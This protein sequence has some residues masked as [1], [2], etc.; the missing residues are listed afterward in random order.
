VSQIDLS[1]K[2][3]RRN[4]LN[5]AKDNKSGHLACAMS[6]VEIVSSLYGETI[7]FNVNDPEDPNRDI[8]ALSKGHGVMAFYSVFYQLGWITDEHVENYL[9]DGSELF[10]LAEDHN[11]GIEISGGSLGHGY[12]VAV[13]MAYGFKRKG[14]KQRVYCIVGDGEIN[15]GSVWEAVLFAQQ[16]YLD[17]ITLIVDANKY[18]A[19]GRTEDIIN[20]E[21]LDKKFEAFGFDVF[22]CDGHDVNALNKAFDNAKK[23]SKPNVVI[24][25]SIKG[26]GISYMEEDNIWHYKKMDKNLEEIA[27]DEV[28][29]RSPGEK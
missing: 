27:F 2:I 26:A 17:N 23:S 19:M 1:P 25:R 8:V 5:L 10:G 4:I 18:Q 29:S 13:G 22:E 14:S 3:L 21:P 9:K 28:D 11:K 7:N 20:L 6:L 24:A 16:H 12:P 15:E